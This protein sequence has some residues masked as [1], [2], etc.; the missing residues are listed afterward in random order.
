ML[1]SK[2]NVSSELLGKVFKQLCEENQTGI[3]QVITK[4]VEVISFAIQ[5]GKIVSIKYKTKQNDEA[6]QEVGNIEEGKYTF[7]ERP[8]VEEMSVDI[9]PPTNEEVLN[10]LLGEAV[11]VPTPSD[12]IEEEVNQLSEGEKEILKTALTEQIGPI[13]G[14]I[15]KEV[16]ATVGD[17]DTAINI[18]ASKVPDANRAQDFKAGAR[19]LLQ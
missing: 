6:L 18:L 4:K 19:H 9:E 14:L 17:L 11:S 15:C 12:P 7:F 1:R 2:E 13:A 10:Y 8:K 3:L 16:F 5:A